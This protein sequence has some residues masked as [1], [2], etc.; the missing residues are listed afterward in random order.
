MPFAFQFTQNSDN[1]ITS[2]TTA[3]NT[4]ADSAIANPEFDPLVPGVQPILPSRTSAVLPYMFGPFVVGRPDT[5]AAV[6]HAL[7]TEQKTLVV[8]A[9]RNADVEAPG[10][11]DV[12]DIGTKIVITRMLRDG[13][14][15]QMLVQGIERFRIEEFTQTEPFLMAR[16]TPVVVPP[17]DSPE[18]EAA[19]RALL[20]SAKDLLQ[21]AHPDEAMQMHAVLAQ[22][23]TPLH[24][25]FLVASL[26]QLDVA[27]EQALLETSTVAKAVALAQSY[28][29]YELQILRMRNRIAERTRSELDREQRE[30]MLRE[31]LKAIQEELGEKSAEQATVDEL[32]DRLAD[33][34]LPEM[35]R[36]EAERELEHLE[37]IPAASPDHQLTRTY[38]EL[39]LE[40]PWRVSTKDQ[41]D[42]A[43]ARQV[44]DE[45]H[46]GL[47]EIK[48]RILEH[49]A[50]MKLNQ[51]AHAPILC[52]VGPPGVGKTSLGKSI[53]RALGRNFERLSLG[54]L[55][56]ESEL[57]GHRRTYIG[58]MPGRLI[59]AIRRAEA[60]NPLIMLDEIDKLGRDFRGDPGSA[61]LEILDPA[62]NS[63]FQ[64]NYLNLP[65]DLSRVFF[66]TTANSMGPIDQPLVDRME[67]IRLAGYTDEEKREIARRYLIPRQMAEAGIDAELLTIPDATLH[68]IITEYTRE[69]GVRQLE[70]AIGRLCRKTARRVAEAQTDPLA[71]QP[72][73]LRSLM[74]PRAHRRERLRQTL[75]PGI[76]TGLAWTEAGGDVLF[77]E[78]LQLPEGRGLKLT[79][80]LGNV[81][82]ESAE[83]ARSYVWSNAARLGIDQAD[84]SK[85]GLHIH[86]PAGAI[87][88]DG[89]SAGIAMV[90]AITSAFLHRPA[91]ADTAMTGEITLT[92][93]VLP[94]GG[95]KEKVLAARAAGIARVV[96][97]A[98]NV[99]ELDEIPDHIRGDLEFF[100]VTSIDEALR[101][102]LDVERN[103]GAT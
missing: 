37:R 38:L 7:A 12:Y 25:V 45:D 78:T 9:Q 24:L 3:Q 96:F 8:V 32:R 98:E 103:A 36:R 51:S 1:S 53:A 99:E 89:P 92:G 58:A 16:V 20:E 4:A 21:L 29:R 65:F 72:A 28:L 27:K 62:Q 31:Q 17:D 15:M 68:A 60:N 35:V 75:R 55:H 41:L 50:V 97:P 48:D 56:D 42:L 102:T 90:T 39:I 30:F 11:D 85:F 93:E 64:D 82:K 66:I 13:P 83:A 49:L 43:H 63:T 5:V 100:P 87:P 95:L 79:G 18:T 52:F 23:Q 81:M 19:V 57:R 70:R 61:L 73:D 80:H 40:L 77:I 2:A 54:G 67:V 33:A 88:K 84:F 86:V 34:D 74:G 14:V 44:L 59:Q 22:T 69:A 46:F 91:R 101:Q 76:A 71:V 26:M 47:Q 6:E 10:P 94:I